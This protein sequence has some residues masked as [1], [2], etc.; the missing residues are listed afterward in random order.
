MAPAAEPVSKTPPK[1]TL[2]AAELHCPNLKM[3]VKMPC[4]STESHGLNLGYAS[5]DGLDN[6]HMALLDFEDVSG[7]ILKAAS[8]HC[9]NKKMRV[10]KPFKAAE[11]HCFNSRLPVKMPFKAAE[12][13]CWSSQMPV[14]M[15]F[16]AAVSHCSRSKIPVRMPFKAAESQSV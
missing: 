16:E 15:P 7:D 14:K 2:K 1:T 5:E 8:S 12:S 10:D 9:L 11:W 6:G 13:L 4:K 3:Q